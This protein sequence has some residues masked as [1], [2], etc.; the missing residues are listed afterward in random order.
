MPDTEDIA[1]LFPGREV[2]CK[3]E[4]IK[5]LPLYFGQYPLA[6]KHIKPLMAALQQS[7]LFMYREEANEAGVKTATFGLA[8][9]WMAGLPDL[10]DDGGE[11]LIQLFSFA[12]KKPR[13]WFDTLPGDEG[14]ALAQAFFEENSDFFV[15]K[16]LPKL[17]AVGLTKAGAES[18]P[19]SEATATPGATSS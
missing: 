8:D 19:D 2:V 12:L 17:Q 3:G 14:I 15:K 4:T 10:L 13:E 7:N 11:A 6:A 18:V 16:V 9:G 5:V 1:V